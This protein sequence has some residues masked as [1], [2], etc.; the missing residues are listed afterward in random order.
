MQSQLFQI[1]IPSLEVSYLILFLLALFFILDET[2][3]LLEPDL[4]LFFYVKT[5]EKI[6][7]PDDDH[8]VKLSKVNSVINDLKLLKLAVG[9]EKKQKVFLKNKFDT[10]K[11]K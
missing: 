1:L 5:D 10:G 8:A 11:I 2:R 7:F 4:Y 9:S 6:K 3:F